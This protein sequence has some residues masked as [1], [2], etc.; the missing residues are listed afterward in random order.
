ML[1]FE[2]RKMSKI[3]DLFA[4]DYCSEE[5]GIRSKLLRQFQILSDGN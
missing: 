5:K 2:Q 1:H 3:L 4:V